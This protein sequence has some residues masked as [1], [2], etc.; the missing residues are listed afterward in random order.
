VPRVVVLNGGHVVYAGSVNDLVDRG[1]QNAPGDSP[2]E[3]GY[4]A[5]LRA[6]AGT[7]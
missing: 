3:R 6:E 2:L 7:S 5:A 4:L 1:H